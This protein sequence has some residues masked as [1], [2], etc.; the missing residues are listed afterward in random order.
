MYVLILTKNGLGYTRANFVQTHPV[1]LLGPKH[2]FSKSGTTD[3]CENEEVGNIANFQ[4]QQIP[5]QGFQMNFA[6]NS[7]KICPNLLFVKIQIQMFTVEK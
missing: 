5:N 4:V 6:Q 3:F 2:F 7:P 1:T